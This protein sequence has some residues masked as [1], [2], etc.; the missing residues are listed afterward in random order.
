MGCILS[1]T[2]TVITAKAEYGAP[3]LYVTYSC[4]LDAYERAVE[5]TKE[6][7]PGAL[8]YKQENP[9]IVKDSQGNERHIFGRENRISKGKM[10]WRIIAPYGQ[11]FKNI[12]IKTDIDSSDRSKI[13]WK[14]HAGSKVDVF[15][16]GKDK[17]TEISVDLDRRVVKVSAISKNKTPSFEMKLQLIKE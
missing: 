5:Y 7:G 9:C 4:N 13:E 17:N 3:Y 8:K 12:T 11:K 10:E 1:K 6:L 14:I 16:C 2:I 15:D